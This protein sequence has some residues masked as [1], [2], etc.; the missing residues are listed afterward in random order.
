[1]AHTTQTQEAQ[2]TNTARGVRQGHVCG[3]G[4]AHLVEVDLAAAVR[5][6]GVHHLV[7][8]C[9][10]IEAPWLVNGGHGASFRHYKGVHGLH[11]WCIGDQCARHGVRG[12][13]HIISE[14]HGRVTA[15]AAA[16]SCSSRGRHSSSRS[17]SSV[18]PGSSWPPWGA[19]P[20]SP[21]ARRSGRGGCVSIF[22]D[23]NRR[24]IGKSQSK[25][26]LKRTQRTPHRGHLPEGDEVLRGRGCPDIQRDVPLGLLPAQGPLRRPCVPAPSHHHGYQLSK[27]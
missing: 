17:S 6:H 13:C 1:V 10:M 20:R 27:T 16:V 11:H 5:V 7:H 21:E 24:Y 18:L 19:C 4:R 23:K 8:Y 22:L 26:P 14:L 2:R 12:S 25:R 9:N 15:A 3:G